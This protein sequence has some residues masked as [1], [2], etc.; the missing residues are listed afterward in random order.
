MSL[1]QAFADFDA[2]LMQR[3]LSSTKEPNITLKQLSKIKNL[4]EQYMNARLI[5]CDVMSELAAEK[6]KSPTHQNKTS[7]DQL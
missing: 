1:E 6:L 5:I 3:L 7:Q 4:Y 2:T